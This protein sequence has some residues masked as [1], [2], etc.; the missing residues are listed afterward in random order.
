MHNMRAA[1]ILSSV[2][3]LSAGAVQAAAQTSSLSAHAGG[4]L[5]LLDAG[6]N[7]SGGVA[8]SP[9]SRVTLMLGV[10][11]THL[12]SRVTT[13]TDGPGG[14]PITSRF[15]GG[16]LTAVS[17]TIRVSL[18]AEGR[19]TPYVLAGVGTGVSKPNVNEHFPTPVSNGVVFGMAGAGLSVPVRDHLSVF[20]DAR[21]M[22]GA[23]GDDGLLAV[24]PVRVG[25]NWR[26]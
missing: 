24:A 11:R 18:F 14:H 20:G 16:T 23:E 7:L 1:L 26:F 2:L 25:V 5:T 4:G 3:L 6:H 21:M 12:D 22:V 10:E 8:W 19:V 9:L 17:G 15:R 13:Q